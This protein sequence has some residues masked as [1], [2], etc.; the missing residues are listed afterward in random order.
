[1]RAI[2]ALLVGAAVAL[3][4]LMAGA[5]PASAIDESVGGV[6]R[7]DGKPVSGVTV[8]ATTPEGAEV[9]SATTDRQGRWE[10]RVPGPGEYTVSVD[11]DELP[12]GVD[13][14]VRSTVATEVGTSQQKSVLFQVGEPIGEG[15][16]APSAAGPSN[17]DR[18]AQ[19]TVEGIRFGLV[20]A[21]AALGLSMIF[22]TTGLT[23]FSH[24]ELI[25]FGA[26][27]AWYLSDLGIPFVLAGLITVVVSGGFGWFQDVTLWRPLRK[28][29]TGL[30]AMMIVSIGLAILLRYT[31]LYIFAGGRRPY[32]EYST[33]SGIEF[34]PVSLAPR[35]LWSMAIC[36][37]A[38]GG[39]VWILSRTRLGKA[40]RAVSDNPA[41]ASASGIDVNHVIRSVW[42]G[43]AALS[44]LAGILLGLSQQVEYQIGY[45]TLLLVFAAVILGGLGTVWG[46]ILGAL[47]VGVF[48]QVSTLVIPSELKDAG[49]LAILVV[50]LL[51][52]PQGILGQRDR[53][54]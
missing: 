16:E 22:G 41:L 34:G 17:W 37:I 43:G 36:V 29:R 10:I 6:I 13:G 50:I 48:I 21:L 5:V 49:A 47:V 12:A 51:V 18:A 8:I 24:G 27:V 3:L 28:R 39:V 25:T 44:G 46:A 19:L 26:I 20:L 4:G 53:V 23:N 35:D 54:G 38:L 15:E 32:P 45:K 2:L 14:I 9:G 31:Y 33:Q 40:T 7:D 52:R 30:I 11:T 42:I 1:M